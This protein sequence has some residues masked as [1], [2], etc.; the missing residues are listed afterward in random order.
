MIKKSF[1]FVD[2]ALLLSKIILLF[3]V[4][5]SLW[6]FRPFIKRWQYYLLRGIFFPLAIFFHLF[7]TKGKNFN[8]ALIALGPIAI[9]FGQG[10]S[11]RAD[12]VGADVAFA[13]AGLQDK[14]PPFPFRHVEQTISQDFNLAVDDMFEQFETT[15]VAAASVAGVYAATFQGRKVAVK[16]LRPNIRQLFLRDVRRLKN[17]AHWAQRFFPLAREM[18]SVAIVETF[19]N[20]TAKELNLRNEASSA[21][22]LAQNFIAMQDKFYVPTVYWQGVSDNVL[23]I[24]WVD[25]FRIDDDENFKKYGLDKEQLLATSAEVFCLQV[26][27]DG[28]FHA[29]LHPG[30]LFF[31][32]RG[33][34]VPIDFG[35]MG[36]IDHN[37]QMFLAEMLSGFLERDY[38]KVAL[39]HEKI[40]LLP[41]DR[42]N[43]Q[44]RKEF[45]AALRAIGE[46]WL[47]KNSNDISLAKFLPQ[48][49]ATLR[50]FG[51]TPRTNLLLLQK[52]IIMAEGLSR[53][54]SRT[55]S[56]WEL[57][58]PFM[59]RWLRDNYAPHKQLIYLLKNW[60]QTDK[61][62]RKDILTDIAK[63]A[64]AG[65]YKLL[66]EGG[67]IERML[68]HDWRVRSLYVIAR[69]II[70]ILRT[71]R[72]RAR[73]PKD[74]AP[75]Y[76]ATQHASHN[77]PSTTKKNNANTHKDKK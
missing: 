63:Q 5:D 48:L 74:V 37:H 64:V 51:M 9:K 28:F 50:Q 11:V 23:T 33:A 16:I 29:D 12:I 70:S 19:E 49:F 42:I 56:I 72:T 69:E 45:T 52:T 59:R 6:V 75:Q 36:R 26:F 13:L 17:L 68:K 55:T 65:F 32:R 7:S 22:E 77:K 35:I 10:L 21:A 47:G 15:P 24:E 44:Y 57:A 18:N 46:V 60:Q 34:L 40:G 38:E 25:G 71:E 31:T 8:R 61:S 27:R 30:N 73:Q 58:E 43:D 41:V 3:G 4:Y 67:V 1:S 39:A 76:S 66:E 62:S 53:M 2:A 14:L 20:I 54:L